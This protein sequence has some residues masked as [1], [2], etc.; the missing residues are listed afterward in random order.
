[1]KVNTITGI[2]VTLL[3]L[4]SIHYLIYDNIKQMANQETNPYNGDNVW[5]YRIIGTILI[6][7]VMGVGRYFKPIDTY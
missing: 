5:T 1:M 3:L 4:T 7:L 6:L 2:L